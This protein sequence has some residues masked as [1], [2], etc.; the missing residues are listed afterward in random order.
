MAFSLPKVLLVGHSLFARLEQALHSPAHPYC[1][2]GFGLRQCTVR[3]FSVPGWN[4]GD[5]SD[6]LVHLQDR[7]RPAFS[8]MRAMTLS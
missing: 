6:M 3:F 2:P 7:V 1:V 5:S 8:A 4:I